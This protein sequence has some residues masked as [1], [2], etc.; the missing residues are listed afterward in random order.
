MPEILGQVNYTLTS[1][2]I[3]VSGNDDTSCNIVLKN[4]EGSIDVS[5]EVQALKIYL[6]GTNKIDSIIELSNYN[7]LDKI[8]ISGKGNCSINGLSS[9]SIQ[10]E[11]DTQI[12]NL[13]RCNV[14]KIN[15]C[16]VDVDANVDFDV[17]GHV[18]ILNSIFNCNSTINSPYLLIDNSKVN[19]EGNPPLNSDNEIS[20]QTCL[21]IVDDETSISCEPCATEEINGEIRPKDFLYLIITDENGDIKDILSRRKLYGYTSTSEVIVDN[22]GKNVKF[23]HAN[24]PGE[25]AT[26]YDKFKDSTHYTNVNL[27]Q[28]IDQTSK[29]YEGR[30]TNYIDDETIFKI[31]HGLYYNYEFEYE[32]ISDEVINQICN[33]TYIYDGHPHSADP[34][35]VEVV[36]EIIDGTYKGRRLNGY[37]LSEVDSRKYQEGIYSLYSYRTTKLSFHD[38]D[39]TELEFP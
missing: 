11:S 38:E 8:A 29:I 27:H 26:P 13:L 7:K 37:D 22:S 6:Y 16:K 20:F 1:G 17:I 36:Q 19:I 33:D 21:N 4:F 18:W 23:S 3:H 15:C 35:T 5:D 9:T 14:L 31:I 30:G 32:A 39:S 12:R 25:P 2:E 10:L 28:R 34:I 24:Q